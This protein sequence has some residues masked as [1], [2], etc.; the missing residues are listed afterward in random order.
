MIDADKVPVA[1]RLD[2][3]KAQKVKLR[4]DEVLNTDSVHDDPVAD[5]LDAKQAIKVAMGNTN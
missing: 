5:R 4:H 1:D 2:A 3:K